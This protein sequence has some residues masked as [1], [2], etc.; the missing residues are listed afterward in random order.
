MTRGQEP[1]IETEGIMAGFTGL[2]TAT[3]LT[4]V[5]PGKRVTSGR[6]GQFEEPVDSLMLA[7]DN[8]K[9]GAQ[10]GFVATIATAN[11]LARGKNIK[12]GQGSTELQWQKKTDLLM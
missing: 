9:Q 8:R 5:L 2:I 7:T 3:N 6:V 4:D 12:K 1:I 11:R 10:S